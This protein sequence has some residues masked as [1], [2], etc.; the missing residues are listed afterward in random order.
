MPSRNSALVGNVH[1]VELCRVGNTSGR[2]D[3]WIGTVPS[4]NYALVGT[5]HLVEL[6]TWRSYAPRGTM[7]N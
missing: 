3:A 4:R 5:V 1:L 6:C 7:P 2:N